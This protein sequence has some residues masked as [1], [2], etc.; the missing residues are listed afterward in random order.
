MQLAFQSVLA[1]V[2]LAMAGVADAGPFEDGQAAYDQHDYTRA[3]QD[4]RPLAD[5]GDA[6]EQNKIGNMY[7]NGRRK[8][9]PRL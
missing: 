2:F 4:W 9:M 5:H 8:I 3:L 7:A 6:K 1:A